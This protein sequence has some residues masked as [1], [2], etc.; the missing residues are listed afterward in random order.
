MTR[1]TAGIPDVRYRC[2]QLN[3]AKALTANRRAG[4]FYATFVADDSLVANILVLTTVALIV[5]RRAE[6]CFSEQAVFF[7]T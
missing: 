1:Y 6:N 2:G 7:W 5:A 3:V 4:N